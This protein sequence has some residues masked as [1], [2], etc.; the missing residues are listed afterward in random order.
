MENRAQEDFAE[1]GRLWKQEYENLE[2]KK[3]TNLE[4]GFKNEENARQ[5]IQKELAVVK[6]ELAVIDILFF[7]KL[8]EKNH[9]MVVKGDPQNHRRSKRKWRWH[10]RKIL[11]RNGQVKK[12]A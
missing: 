9:E 2:K 1:E 8:E 6:D 5:V 3:T 12:I 11:L 4:E 10:T 7:Q